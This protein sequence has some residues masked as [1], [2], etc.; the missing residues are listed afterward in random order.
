MDIRLYHQVSNIFCCIIEVIVAFLFSYEVTLTGLGVYLLLSIMLWLLAK[1]I[2]KN[3][4]KVNEYDDSA[5][6]SVEIIENTRTI[7]L[8]NKESFFLRKFTNKL[9]SFRGYQTKVN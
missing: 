6:F 1:Q 4:H 7:Q 5:N 3:I 2:R 8:L 9:R